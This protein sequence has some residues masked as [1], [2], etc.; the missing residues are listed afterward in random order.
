MRSGALGMV[1]HG[2]AIGEIFY[3]DASEKSSEAYSFH[4]GGPG[5]LWLIHPFL[6]CGGA[7]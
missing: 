6:P 2:T 4:E 3:S 5:C 7:E 1:G